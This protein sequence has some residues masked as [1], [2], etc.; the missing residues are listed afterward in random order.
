[1]ENLFKKKK[2][3]IF[4]FDGTIADSLH[5]HENAFKKA[6]AIHSV[7]FEYKDHLG[8]STED[9]MRAIF[10][11]N[12]YAIDEAELKRLTKEK[13]TLANELYKNA[14]QFIPGALA[15]IEL[16]HVNRF[17]LFIGSSGSR[18]NVTTGLHKLGID[19]YFEMIVTA[20]DI[21]CSKPHPE[22][23]QKILDSKKMDP[24]SVLVIEDAES[25]I[26][27]AIAAGLDVVCINNELK[28]AR[29]ADKHVWFA[30]FKSLSNQLQSRL[31]HA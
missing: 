23:F 12:R 21:S 29:V 5:L 31:P 22:V 2:S 1:M 30:D 28:I 7:K 18:L 3:I 24:A 8:M 17:R 26:Q 16:L 11:S 10:I 14:L 9:A 6:L 20:D 25:G 4:D 15:F 27:A 13:R 19:K